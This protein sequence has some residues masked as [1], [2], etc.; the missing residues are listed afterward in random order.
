MST[1][2][3]ATTA[4][5]Y[6]EIQAFIRELEEQADA[7]KQ[8]MI[9]ELDARQADSLQAGEYTVRYS[10][11]ESSRLDSAKLKTDHADLYIAYS[12]K[13]TSTRFPSGVEKAPYSATRPKDAVQSL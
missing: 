12:R 10:L 13:T 11:Y 5:E 9:R 3:M 6:R 1:V 4:R 2:E 7:L 8:Q